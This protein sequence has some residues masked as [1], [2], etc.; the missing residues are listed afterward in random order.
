MIR[1]IPAKLAH[2]LAPLGFRVYSELF[3]KKEPPVWEPFTWKGIYFPNRLGLAGGMDKNA[4]WLDVWPALGCGF[5]EVGTITPRPQ[6]PNPGTILRRSWKDHNLWNKMGFPSAGVREVAI[7][8]SQGDSPIP[9]FANIGKNR[10]T[11]NQ[12]A[13]EDFIDCVESLKDYVDAFVVNVSSPNTQ[14]LRQLQNKKFLS[15]LISTMMTKTPKTPIFL[16]LSPDL[17][18]SELRECLEAG[19]ESS[20]NGLVLTNTT[21]HR[22]P[23]CSFP[24]DG[25][26]AGRDLAERSVAVLKETVKFLGSHRENLLIVSVGGVLSPENVKERLD[27]GADLVE[28]YSALA[29][30][31]PGFFQQ[32]ASWFQQAKKE[33]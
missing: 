31:G 15:H 13:E 21:T 10:D 16:K 14:G 4:E 7:G 11:P 24:S 2:E 26:L 12:H 33:S 8:L 28:V 22:P 23:S 9:V 32:V 3:C 18:T 17:T 1:Y 20:I 19:L 6:K 25:G 29:F 30:R 5:V 27:L